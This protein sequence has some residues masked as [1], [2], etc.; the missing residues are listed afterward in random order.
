MRP[1]AGN[2]ANVSYWTYP[3]HRGRGFATRAL[4]LLMEV[5][6]DFDALEALIDADNDASIA[7]ALACGFTRGC[8]RDGRV[9]FRRA[10][11]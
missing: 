10:P 5:G 4:R 2:V 7:V 3:P 1:T 9:V 8:V 11:L 6:H